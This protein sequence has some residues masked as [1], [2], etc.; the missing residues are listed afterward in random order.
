MTTLLAINEQFSVVHNRHQQELCV[1]Q[2]LHLHRRQQAVDTEV[3]E[4]EHLLKEQGRELRSLS[5]YPTFVYVPPRPDPPAEVTLSPATTS[6]DMGS[7]ITLS[8]VSGRKRPRR[9]CAADRAKR[10]LLKDTIRQLSELV[11]EEGASRRLGQCE[12]IQA[13]IRTIKALSDSRL[14][15]R[16]ELDIMGIES[17]SLGAMSCAALIVAPRSC[18]DHYLASR[19]PPSAR[20]LLCPVMPACSL[21]TLLC[22][23]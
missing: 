11:K 17:Q 16:Q 6:V 21:A 2:Q 3:R 15:A 20:L 13:G 8:P 23:L 1:L 7:S 14:I 10:A 22:T 4:V 12:A 19:S 5:L 18:S 9:Q